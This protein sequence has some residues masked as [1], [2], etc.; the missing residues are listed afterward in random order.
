M[1]LL[2]II[3][4]VI[5]RTEVAP[6]ASL[7]PMHP[8]GPGAPEQPRGFRAMPFFRARLCAAGVPPPTPDPSVA[9]THAET[10][11]TDNWISELAARDPENDAGRLPDRAA[12]SARH[13]GGDMKQTRAH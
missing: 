5:S 2:H 9:C 3:G 8:A 4:P 1:I 6:F 10:K 7:V 11:R 12:G 13:G